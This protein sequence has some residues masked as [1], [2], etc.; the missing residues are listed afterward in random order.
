[1]KRTKKTLM[2]KVIE[3]SYSQSLGY[4]VSIQDLIVSLLKEAEGDF[5]TVKKAIHVDQ[6][7]LSYWVDDLGLREE[8]NEIRLLYYRSIHPRR[9]GISGIHSPQL[10]ETE[11]NGLTVCVS[12]ETSF[13][14][15][16]GVAVKVETDRVEFHGVDD[17]GLSKHVFLRVTPQ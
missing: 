14:D 13:E 10:T 1:M 17:N 12:C 11:V 16:N 8:V 15:H 7:S 3:S 5:T 2:M 6:T 4:N 9:R